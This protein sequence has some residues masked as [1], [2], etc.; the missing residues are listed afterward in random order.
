MH[1]DE[2]PLAGS[3]SLTWLNEWTLIIDWGGAGNFQSVSDAL[4][5]VRAELKVRPLRY[6]V[7]D[8]LNVIDFDPSLRGPA[9]VLLKEAKA[10]GM[11]ELIV[12]ARMPALRMLAFGLGMA[13]GSRTRV[14]LTRSEAE[15]YCNNSGVAELVSPQ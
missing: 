14:F 1:S 4:A 13:A 10:R 5:A 15:A 8:T 3:A 2:E 6:L 11:K 9:D 12:V 7:C